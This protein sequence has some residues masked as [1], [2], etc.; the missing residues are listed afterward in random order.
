[1]LVLQSGPTT[2]PVSSIT[3]HGVSN[4]SLTYIHIK[5]IEH[6]LTVTV[7]NSMFHFAG[8]TRHMAARCTLIWELHVGSRAYILEMKSHSESRG[9]AQDNAETDTK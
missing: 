5:I 4:S 9:D 6:G 7:P 8:E 3:G 1:M 2:A